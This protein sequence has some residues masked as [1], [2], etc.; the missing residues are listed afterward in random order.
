MADDFPFLFSC[1]FYQ[2]QVFVMGHTERVQLEHETVRRK[3]K[4]LGDRR[5]TSRSCRR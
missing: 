4:A 5:S 2:E 3:V 1:E